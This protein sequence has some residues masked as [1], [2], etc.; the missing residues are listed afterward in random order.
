MHC[1]RGATYRLPHVRCFFVRLLQ[2][3]HEARIVEVR[4]NV[5]VAPDPCKV[6]RAQ[7][8]ALHERGAFLVL[9]EEVLLREARATYVEERRMHARES[10]VRRQALV[11][12]L[13]PAR[14]VRRLHESRKPTETSRPLSDMASAHCATA[15]ARR[16]TQ[17]RHVRDRTE[18]LHHVL[19]PR[20]ERLHFGCALRGAQLG[21]PASVAGRTGTSILRAAARSSTAGS[22]GRPAAPRPA[23]ETHSAPAHTTGR[24]SHGP[25]PPPTPWSSC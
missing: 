21:G 4:E 16:R 6:G 17:Q 25:R 14:G 23:P 7:V 19:V 22:C 8:R 13:E 9:G 18:A 15:L 10:A 3:V 2:R 24:P 5:Q 12:A 1:V 20:L 11:H